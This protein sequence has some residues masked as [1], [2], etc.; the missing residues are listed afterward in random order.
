MPSPDR[1]P[2]L[3]ASF[4]LIGVAALLGLGVWQVQRAAWKDALIAGRTARLVQP[5]VALPEDLADLDG[6]EFRRVWVVGRFD[7]AREM[8][9]LK[10]AMD[11]RSGYHVVTPLR[12]DGGGA[13][14]VDR[15]WVPLERR[16]AGSRAAG[17]VDGT[18]IVEGIL[19]RGDDPGP[20]TPENDPALVA[21]YW[22]D[23]AA[24]AAAAGIVAPALIVEAGPDPMPGGLPEGGQTATAARN[25]HRGY[26]LTWSALAVV[27]AVI[28]LGYRRPQRRPLGP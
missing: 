23:P 9:V 24:M 15:G 19:R 26:A 4:A 7:H 22:L 8:T 20:F 12:I 25:M 27:L 6:W 11:G 28:Y 1:P 3:V 18:V 10:P 14:L 5:P 21:W 13:V 17:Q 16:D 2:W